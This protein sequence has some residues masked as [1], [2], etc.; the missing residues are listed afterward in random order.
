MKKVLIVGGNSYLGRTLEEYLNQYPELYT[1]KK[2]SVRDSA[3]EDMSFAEFDVIYHTAAIVHRNEKKV[4]AEDYFAVNSN[5]AEKIAQKA[6]AEGVKQFIF[7]S[8]VGVYG[9]LSGMIDKNT[10][11]KPVTLY[12]KSKLE[13]EGKINALASDSFRVAVLRPPIIYGKECKGNFTRLEWL[14]LKSPIFP[15]YNNTRSMLYIK[16]LNIFVEQLIAREREGLFFPQDAE[17]VSTWEM[18]SLIRAE[19]GKRMLGIKV[20]NPLIKALDK[21]I[22]LFEKLWG[23]LCFVPELSRIE[24]I[25]Y[26]KYSLQEAIREIES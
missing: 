3:W 1:V 19:K 25:D 24:G 16:N 7:V 26:Q 6:K 5:L 9:M 21:R 11:T 10:E 23:D 18:V 12:G 15:K 20:F 4:P 8:T 14:A 13:A 17:Y 22:S 2:I